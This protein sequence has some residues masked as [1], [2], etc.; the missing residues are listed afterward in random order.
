[1][2]KVDVF[3]KFDYIDEVVILRRFYNNKNRMGLCYF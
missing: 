2:V 3:G 1:M